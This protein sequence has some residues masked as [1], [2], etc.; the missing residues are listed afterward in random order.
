MFT[1]DPSCLVFSIR[2]V[3][4]LTRQISDYLTKLV[5]SLWLYLMGYYL[6]P[7]SYD[8]IKPSSNYEN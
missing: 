8:Q 1:F 3:K 2:T 7:K 4:D 6:R 5:L